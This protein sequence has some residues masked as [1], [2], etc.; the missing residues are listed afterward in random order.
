MFLMLLSRTA[1]DWFTK[2]TIPSLLTAVRNL[3]WKM[4]KTQTSA[5]AKGSRAESL[6]SPWP[7]PLQLPSHKDVAKKS[8]QRREHG[9]NCQMIRN[10]FSEPFFF[11]FKV[12]AVTPWG[13]DFIK[14]WEICYEWRKAPKSTET[15]IHCPW[16]S[17]ECSFNHHLHVHTSEG[18]AQS[19]QQE[20]TAKSTFVKKV[21][22]EG[23]KSNVM[24]PPFL[25]D[26]K[27][28][29]IW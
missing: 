3:G 27:V 14:R 19:S 15:Q 9:G 8:S 23:W 4:A 17:T 1:G 12:K 21:L 28:K 16:P 18:L 6:P 10:N 5:C 11:S 26:I 13:W 20:L 25:G 7:P 29:I 24:V 22:V 2:L